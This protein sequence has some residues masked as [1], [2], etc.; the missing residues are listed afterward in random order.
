MTGFSYKNEN[1]SYEIEIGEGYT[2]NDEKLIEFGK[3]YWNHPKRIKLKI[4]EEI[5]LTTVKKDL[6]GRLMIEGVNKYMQNGNTPDGKRTY[7]EKAHM[8]LHMKTHQ[9]VYKMEVKVE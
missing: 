6:S 5:N 2:G 9:A 8:M 4:N 1:G 3:R 7:P